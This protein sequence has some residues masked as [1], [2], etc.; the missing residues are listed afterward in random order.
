MI[1]KIQSIKSNGICIAFESHFEVGLDGLQF[2]NVTGR[3]R[4]GIS[5]GSKLSGY[6][7]SHVGG[8]SENQNIFLHYPFKVKRCARCEL[9]LLS[10]SYFL[11]MSLNS[12]AE[13]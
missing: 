13:G 6:R 9:N 12:S 8:G 3:E 1:R 5:F 11:R 7:H 2:L 10:G 4:N